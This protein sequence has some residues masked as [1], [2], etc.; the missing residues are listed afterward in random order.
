MPLLLA[1]QSRYIVL[2]RAHG[3]EPVRLLLKV[4]EFSLSPIGMESVTRKSTE[5]PKWSILT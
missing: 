3:S 1:V 2:S 4:E 5:S